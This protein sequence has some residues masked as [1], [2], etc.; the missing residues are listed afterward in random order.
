MTFHEERKRSGGLLFIQWPVN[1]M[2]QTEVELRELHT[3]F[4]HPSTYALVN[5]LT[6]EAAEQ[7]WITVGPHCSILDNRVHRIP[8]K[9]SPRPREKFRDDVFQ[10]TCS[11]LWII[12][13]D[14]ALES[15]D[16]LSICERYRSIIRR[17][18]NKLKVDF[19][20][21]DERHD[22]HLQSIRV[23]QQLDQTSSLRVCSFFDLFLEFHCPM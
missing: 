9:Y 15:H 22:C 5:L 12:A 17:V 7:T 1:N 10:N 3:Q 2:L 14:T 23:T 20:D 13:K 16:S 6:N 19:P 8:R 18:Y 21:M 4:G 11:Q